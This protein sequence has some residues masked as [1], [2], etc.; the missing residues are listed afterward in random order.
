MDNIDVVPENSASQRGL[1]ATES[2]LRTRGVKDV[3]LDDSP[4]K[5]AVP[6]EPPSWM[7]LNHCVVQHGMRALPQLQSVE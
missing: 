7:S 6:T 3:D 1:M 4:V 5:R 2:Q